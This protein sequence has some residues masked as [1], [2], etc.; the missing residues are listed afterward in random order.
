MPLTTPDDVSELYDRVIADLEATLAP[1]GGKPFLNGSWL[2]ALVVAYSNRIFD[3]YAALDNAALEALPDTA[4]DN[5]G[6]WGAIFGV[7][8][9][10]GSTSGGNTVATGTVGKIVPAG[11][12]LATGD[13]RRYEVRVASAVST[14]SLA[15]ASITRSGSTATLTT[16]AKHGLGSQVLVTVTGAVE[17]EY[18]VVDSPITIVDDVTIEYEVSGTP[19]T[20]ATGTILLGFDSAALLIESEDFGEDQDLEFDAALQFE[21]PI[22][23]VDST[24]RVDF[25]E[26]GGG[27]DRETNSALRDRLLFQIQNPVAHFNVAEIVTVALSVPGVTR[28]FV[29]EITPD[30]GQVTVYFTRDNDA[31][32]IPSGTEVAAVKAV[33]DAIRPANTDTAD[34]IVA[35]PSAVLVDF[36]FTDLQ[37]DT[38]T[39]KAA[40]EASLEQFFAER[41]EVGEDVDSDAYRSAI[42]NTVDT[43]NGDRV[44]T[45]TLSGP[46]GD[47]SVSAGEIAT[48]G[49]V[50][51]S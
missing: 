50:T 18:N 28:V 19:S 20:P 11:A 31:D 8:R 51:F 47:V 26:V 39:M 27:A 38:G 4:S 44:T 17:T 34:L 15:V 24:T 30:V 22:A 48:L 1:V 40:V 16:A 35:A 45:F 6:R 13:G 43:T 23:G 49:N 32:P 12:F 37:P 14:K 41:T 36:T 46:V 21:S 7:V 2:R 42:Y 10:P 29:F 33:L 9:I 3:F 25:D 5:L